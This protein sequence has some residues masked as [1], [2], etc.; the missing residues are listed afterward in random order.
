MSS[1]TS[2]SLM[3][4]NVDF[5]AV[6]RCVGNDILIFITAMIG[7]LVL[8][9]VRIKASAVR[10]AC[11]ES[12]ASDAK[13]VS[14]SIAHESDALSSSPVSAPENQCQIDRHPETLQSKT[15]FDVNEKIVLMQQYASA[16]NMKETLRSFRE[17]ERSGESLTSAMYN[18]VMRAWINCG[19]IFAAESW[20]EQIKDAKMTDEMSFISLMR[21]LVKVRD[22]EKAHN[23]F[24]QMQDDGMP[25]SSAV[26]DELLRGFANEGLLDEG[27][28][29]LKE[30]D[31]A[32]VQ[33][34][35]LTMETISRL[36]SSARNLGPRFKS[37][38]QICDEYGVV[39]KSIDRSSCADPP[40][41]PRLARVICEASA[42][43]PKA[44]LHNVEVKGSFAGIKALRRTLKQLG[45]LDRPESAGQCFDG[46]WVTDHGMT[47]IIEGKIV[48]WSHQR[49]SRLRFTSTDRL[50][51]TLNVYGELAEGKDRKSVV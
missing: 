27:M 31:A 7:F 23:L 17:I 13:C 44:Y 41:I 5:E 29:L 50:A 37:L 39:P 10:C 40:P 11:E 30:G 3:S 25:P 43:A 45:L 15:H 16:G 21:A 9:R 2:S 22:Y 51:C 46:H 20:M 49:A 42:V 6:F 32:G 38:V 35:S 48:R 8:H 24:R 14:E 47:V 12:L 34:T 4:V 36:L 1:V 26:F 18:T 19:N 28:S 33:P